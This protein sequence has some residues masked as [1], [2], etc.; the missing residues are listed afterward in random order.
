MNNLDILKKEFY[1]DDETFLQNF[2]NLNKKNID[3]ITIDDIINIIHHDCTI[4]L[5]YGCRIFTKNCQT[6]YITKSECEEYIRN[7]FSREFNSNTDN[8]QCPSCRT[9]RG[10]D[11]EMHTWK[12][13]YKGRNC[14]IVERNLPEAKS[15]AIYTGIYNKEAYPYI[16]GD[17][18]E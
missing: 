8:C 18:I 2:Y 14:I 5:C 4:C 10:E 7:Y 3:N 17:F 9:K 16:K 6:E 12:L 15:H 11:N 1:E 13:S